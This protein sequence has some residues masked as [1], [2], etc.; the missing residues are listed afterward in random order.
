MTRTPGAFKNQ[1]MIKILFFGRSCKAY[2]RLFQDRSPRVELFCNHCTRTLHKHG[3]YTRWVTSKRDRFQIRIYRWLCPNCRSTVS[4]LPDFLAPWARFKTCVREAAIV[5]KRQHHSYRQIAIGI[6]TP[7]TGLSSSTVKRWWKRYVSQ[8][9]T[10]SLWMAR[11]LVIAG[12]HEDLL[13]RYANPIDSTPM[14][15]L[16]WFEHVLKHYAPDRSRL[17]GFW[18]FL[19]AKLPCKLLL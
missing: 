15:T 3:F 5:R 7:I 19:N 10:T 12:F 11:Q 14:A 17:R 16:D 4:L 8:V 13:A 6:T 18:S 1:H 9:S 2:L